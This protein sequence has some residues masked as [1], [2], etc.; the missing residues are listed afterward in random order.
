VANRYSSGVKTWLIRGLW[1]LLLAVP[2][3]AVGGAVSAVSRLPELHPRHTLISDLEPRAAEM[4]EAFT[5]AEY[6][7]REQK[8]FDE[9]RD[10]VERVVSAS[11]NPDVPSRYTQDS[12]SHPSRIDAKWNHT[13]ILDTP[14]PSGGALL[15]HGLTDGPYSMRAVA[16]K[17]HALGYYTVSLRMQGH[18]TV[19]GGLVNTTW[20]DWSAAVRMGA[21]HVRQRIGPDLPMVL[22]GYSNGGALVTKYALD[23]LYDSTLPPPSKLILISPMIGVSPAAGLAGAI[24]LL[25]PIVEKARWID[26]VP[27][28]NPYKYNSFPA[29]AGRQTARVTR[30][31]SQ[32]LAAAAADGR[33]AGM[34]PVLAFQSILDTTVSTA[35]VAY[36]LLDRL[37][38]QRNELVLFDMNRQSRVDAFTRGD[39]VLPRLIGDGTRPY[40]VT[41]VTNTT[42][43]TLEVSAKTAASGALTIRDEALGM[44]WPDSLYSLSHVALPFPTDDPIYGSEGNGRE[45]GGISLGRLSPRGE[46]GALIIPAEVLMRVTWNPF[47][48][49]LARRVEEWVAAPKAP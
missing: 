34:P 5:L 41:L 30:A 13:N 12:R 8:V 17:L 33:I 47:Y 48:P 25:G 29:N 7:A 21:R 39:A 3:L 9:A 28:Y 23:A 15:I 24:S 49:Y 38:A 46:K 37:P 31:L 10:E 27:E 1:A 22:V 32:E 36:D 18:G 19:P 16:E 35:A 2:L 14:A 11:A 26:V 43:D 20:E 6:I 40:A 4:T 42:A 45:V 44:S